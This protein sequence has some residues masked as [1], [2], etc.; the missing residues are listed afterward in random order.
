MRKYYPRVGTIFPDRSTLIEKLEESGW[1]FEG[2]GTSLSP[3]T[4]RVTGLN[5]GV[6]DKNRDLW[7]MIDLKPY[8]GGIKVT[9]VSKLKISDYTQ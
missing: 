3:R 2:A 4:G 7:L 5:I 1:E 9:K 8:R 6:Q